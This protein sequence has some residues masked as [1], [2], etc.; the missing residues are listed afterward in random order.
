[1]I[2]TRIT[3][4]DCITRLK[5]DELMQRVVVTK[6]P[7]GGKHDQMARIVDVEE[8]DDGRKIK[9][10]DVLRNR[11]YNWRTKTPY[12]GMGFPKEGEKYRVYKLQHLNGRFEWVDTTPWCWNKFHAWRYHVTSEGYEGCDEYHTH[13]PRRVYYKQAKFCGSDQAETEVERVEFTEGTVK[14][15]F[16][17]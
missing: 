15:E 7:V 17:T 1:M 14:V 16:D 9:A 11:G 4:D 10:I 8:N 12:P 2:K 6:H 3:I 13:E 5:S